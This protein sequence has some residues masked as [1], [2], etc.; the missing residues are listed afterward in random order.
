MSQV[1]SLPEP[2]TNVHYKYVSYVL[3]VVLIVGILQNSFTMAALIRVHKGIELTTRLLLMALAATDISNLLVWYG[4][5][6]FA[7]F[8]LNYMTNGSFYFRAVYESD[9]VCKPLRGLGYF[10]LHC[11]HWLYVLVNAD[12]LLVVLMPYRSHRYYRE[13]FLLLLSGILM[14]IGLITTGF[15]TLMYSVKH[16]TVSAI[17]PSASINSK[18]TNT[19][20]N[21]GFKI[22]AK[23]FG[24]YLLGLL[25]YTLIPYRT[26]YLNKIKFILPKIHVR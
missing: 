26:S 4:L 11:S 6:G 13:R 25:V 17:Q 5:E 14:A 1:I 15:S 22:G 8:G 24:V 2:W 19:R 3:P 7:D 12:R 18:F 10:G 9:F 21:H 20:V 16:S 23:S